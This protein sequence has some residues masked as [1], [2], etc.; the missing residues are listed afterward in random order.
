[1]KQKVLLGSYTKAESK[2]IYQV[3]LDTDAGRLS[4]LQLVAEADN[5]TYLVESK[6]KQ[7]VYSVGRVNGL[8]G[9]ISWR[10]SDNGERYEFV[11]AVTAEGSSPCF[12]SISRDLVFGANYHKGCTDVL[13]VGKD[14]SLTLTD[15]VQHSGSGPNKERQAGPHAHYA[16]VTP[17]GK[18]LVVVDLGT[19]QVYTF[20]IDYDSGKLSSAS[21]YQ[22][23]PA[24]GPR[25]MVFHPTQS[26][27]YLFTEMSN[28]VVVL[29]YTE[30]NGSFTRLQTVPTLP[31]DFKEFSGG[32]AIRISSDGKYLY[33]SN[34]GHESI[35]V[36]S[37]ADD[38]RSVSFVEH[39]PTEG[40]HPRDFNIDPSGAYLI[41]ANMQTNNL[42]LF[43]RDAN[44]G[45]LRLLQKDFKA[46]EAVCIVYQ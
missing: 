26:V 14:G 37:V 46:P 39:V 25:H 38:G 45:K 22:C 28:E 3:T 29:A 5:P 9:T 31:A 35:V 23:E 8:G 12:V 13:R 10:C 42:T 44:S 30:S 43:S 33:A 19:D 27:A 20:A 2:G 36:F 32:A 6:N 17:D 21:V 4:D 1:M 16:D 7:Y 41:V 24:Q 40:K 18:Y 11:N 15:N 34:R